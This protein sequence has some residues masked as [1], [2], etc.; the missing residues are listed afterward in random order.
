MGYVEIFRPDGSVTKLSG[1]KIVWED[2][3]FF[4]DACETVKPVFGSEVTSSDGLDLI[5]LCIDCKKHPKKAA[6]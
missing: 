3:S 2:K 5:Q 4:C 6:Q 1:G